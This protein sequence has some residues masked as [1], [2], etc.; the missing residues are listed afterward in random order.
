MFGSINSPGM[1]TT[2]GTY[3]TQANRLITQSSPRDS[4]SKSSYCQYS[5][6][7]KA[8]SLVTY[9][10]PIRANDTLVWSFRSDSLILSWWGDTSYTAGDSVPYIREQIYLRT[11]GTSQTL[12]GTYREVR[13]RQRLLQPL[14]PGSADSA[15]LAR[16]DTLFTKTYQKLQENLLSFQ[17]GKLT[18]TARALATWADFEVMKWNGDF[19]LSYQVDSTRYDIT[20][21]KIDGNTVTETGRKTGEVVTRRL[22]RVEPG[23]LIWGDES[24]SSSDTS[25]HSGTKHTAP[26]SCPDGVDWFWKFRDENR[27]SPLNAR[28][29]SASPRKDS[30]MESSWDPRALF[31]TMQIPT[32]R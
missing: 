24:F 16:M 29:S 26:T 2:Y 11:S 12:N 28:Q 8:D 3:Q 21:K 31:G 13:L 19:P 5:Q 22:V 27:K 15:M 17:D 14:P 25:H 7:G 10:Y 1:V 4:V 9:E 20:I 18:A 6:S 30:R 32:P 23:A